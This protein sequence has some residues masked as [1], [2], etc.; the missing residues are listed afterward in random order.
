ME[1]VGPTQPEVKG[2]MPPDRMGL[3][4]ARFQTQKTRFFFVSD[5]AT[6]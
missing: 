2:F 5:A 4:E 6:K 1:L 3:K